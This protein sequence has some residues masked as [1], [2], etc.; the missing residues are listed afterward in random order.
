L[1]FLF[2]LL[3]LLLLAAYCCCYC[4]LLLIAAASPVSAAVAAAA[5]SLDP[6]YCS[7]CCS[8]LLLLLLLLLVSAAPVCSR[9]SACARNHD[10]I[11]VRPR[12]DTVMVAARHARR[13]QRHGDGTATARYGTAA[14]LQAS[15]GRGR[16]C[17]RKQQKQQP[18]WPTVSCEE[19]PWR[20]ELRRDDPSRAVRLATG[21]VEF[22]TTARTDPSDLACGKSRTV[23]PTE[24]GAEQS[25]QPQQ[26]TT[27]HDSRTAA[28]AISAAARAADHLRSGWAACA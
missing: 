17:W 26:H 8:C 22:D 3:L 25:G 19:T 16:P 12:C 15:C 27:P 7:C 20:I 13:V 9:P 2:L 28:Q 24:P 4:L 18:G 14:A 21:R 1:L 10:D 5:S 11:R 6:A 23:G